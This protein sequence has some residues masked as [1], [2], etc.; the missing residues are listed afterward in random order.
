MLSEYERTGKLQG[1]IDILID[2]QGY[3]AW[4]YFGTTNWHKTC[5]E[6]KAYMVK[7][8]GYQP[9]LVKTRFSKGM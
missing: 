4:E 8:Y 7:T 3:G 2:R 9:H 6:A 5:K 1:K